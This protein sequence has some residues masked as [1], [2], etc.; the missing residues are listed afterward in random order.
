MSISYTIEHVNAQ[1]A[2]GDTILI[3]GYQ[4]HTD[5]VLVDTTTDPK[6]GDITT[7][8][9][10][11]NGD[12]DYPAQAIYRCANQKRAG[13]EIKRLTATFITWAKAEDSVSG[14]VTRKQVRTG[15]FL[16]IPAG[17][18]LTAEQLRDFVQQ[19]FSLWYTP[20]DSIVGTAMPADYIASMLFGITQVK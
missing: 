10:V 4:L 8:Y 7:T 11:A 13:E 6:T 12:P 5:L 9:V 1:N 19:G 18:K 2:D 20:T 16:E 15:N 17:T 14:L 3:A